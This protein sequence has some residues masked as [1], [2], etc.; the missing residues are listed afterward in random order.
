MARAEVEVEVEEE[1]E[2]GKDKRLQRKI[3]STQRRKGGR[4][5]KNQSCCKGKLLFLKRGSYFLCFRE[6]RKWLEL[7]RRRALHRG[8]LLLACT[9]PVREST[10]LDFMIEGS[11]TECRGPYT[12]AQIKAD[13]ELRGGL[14]LSDKEIESYLGKQSGFLYAI[15]GVKKSRAVLG[16]WQGNGSNATG[17]VCQIVSEGEHKGKKRWDEPYRG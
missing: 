15:E 7:R 8:R 5:P 13:P 11:L 9:Q 17:L 16:T 3:S 10:R 2:E 14:Q 1:E 4:G 12:A 6:K